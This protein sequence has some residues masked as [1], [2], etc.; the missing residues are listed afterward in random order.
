VLLLMPKKKK[1]ST[2]EK[3]AARKQADDLVG[4]GNGHLERALAARLEKNLAATLDALALA[5]DAYQKATVATGSVHLDSMYNLGVCQAIRSNI[6]TRLRKQAE[7]LA[8]RALAR[9]HFNRVLA[10]DTSGRSETLALAHTSIA[11]LLVQGTPRRI[12]EPGDSASGLADDALQDLQ[13]AINHINT[14]LSIHGNLG[15]LATVASSHLQA[16]DAHALSM[17]WSILASNTSEAFRHCEAACQRYDEG[18]RSPAPV[19]DLQ[20]LEQKAKALHG[21]CCWAFENNIGENFRAQFSAALGCAYETAKAVVALVPP[22]GGKSVGE[23]LVVC[24]DICELNNNLAE[25]LQLYQ[26]AVEIAPI[27]DGFAAAADLLLDEGRARLLA[28]ATEGADAAAAVETVRRSAEAFKMA[29][30]TDPSSIVYVYNFACASALALNESAC[31]QALNELQKKRAAGGKMGAEAAAL[32]ADIAHDVDF[33]RVRQT[34]WFAH[35][36]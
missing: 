14:A 11:S 23:L 2:K 25:A 18:L 12:E 3:Q 20:L 32:L 22:G 27:A 21:L 24:G 7:S 6:A 13:Q 8:A 34:P 15:D 31:L 36:K 33:N 9:E 19:N 10:G 29:A 17:R 30:Q 1:V 35:I 26:R 28:A 16:G 5:E 4:V